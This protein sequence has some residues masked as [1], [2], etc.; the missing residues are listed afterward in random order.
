MLFIEPPPFARRPHTLMILTCPACSTKYVVKDG[1]IPPAGRQ[2]RC[3]SCKHS[4][5]QDS[6]ALDAATPGAEDPS[7]E[8]HEDE[9]APSR[10]PAPRSRAKEQASSSANKPMLSKTNQWMLAVAVIVFIAAAAFAAVVAR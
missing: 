9:V 3:A 10:A 2:V 8:T 7:S 1:A 6:E 4:W 5:H